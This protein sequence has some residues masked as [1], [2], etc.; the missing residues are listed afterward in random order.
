MVSATKMAI[1]L[2]RTEAQKLMADVPEGKAFQCHDGQ[3]FRNLRELA[4]GLSRMTD[5]TYAYHVNATNN[6]FANWIRE[7]IG[8]EN[9]AACLEQTASRSDAA[10]IAEVRINYLS[11]I[12]Q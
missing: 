7:V 11:A 1:K 9:A 10:K 8:D 6:D 12:T 2:L 4:T 3:S 5:E